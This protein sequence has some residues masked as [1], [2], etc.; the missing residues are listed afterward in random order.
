MSCC[1]ILIFSMLI[2]VLFIFSYKV[3]KIKSRLKME[4]KD[5]KASFMQK[6]LFTSEVKNESRPIQQQFSRA[7]SDVDVNNI[8]KEIFRQRSTFAQSIHN[9]RKD[10]NKKIL[11]Q[12]YMQERS[13]TIKRQQSNLNDMASTDSNN[14][15]ISK[16]GNSQT[17]TQNQIGINKTLNSQSNQSTINNSHLPQQ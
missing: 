9:L 4:A 8:N 10:S 14:Q 15:A 3:H 7:Q 5:F 12:N 16:S 17:T 11:D 13:L 6:S 2:I 1:L